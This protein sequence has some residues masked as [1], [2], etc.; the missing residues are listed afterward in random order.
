ME[1]R[2]T[3]DTKSEKISKDDLIS[4]LQSEI[5]SLK[6]ELTSLKQKFKIKKKRSTIS[7]KTSKLLPELIERCDVGFINVLSFLSTK[8]VLNA[9]SINREVVEFV[10][11]QQR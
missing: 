4:K 3:I 10:S 5:L 2:K 9:L 6:S 1:E 11:G 7:S 8:D